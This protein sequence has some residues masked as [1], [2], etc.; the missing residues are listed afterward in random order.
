MRHTMSP[1]ISLRMETKGRGIKMALL[2]SSGI[3]E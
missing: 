3:A 2:N 1:T